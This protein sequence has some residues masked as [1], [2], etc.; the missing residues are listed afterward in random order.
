V[1]VSRNDIAT[2]R[3]QVVF[4]SHNAVV[5]KPTSSEKK[6]MISKTV[7]KSRKVRDTSDDATSD[8]RLGSKELPISATHD[9][10]AELRK[11]KKSSDILCDRQRII[12]PT[13]KARSSSKINTVKKELVK[14]L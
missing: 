5:K 9:Q 11:S 2:G 1:P 12:K 3:G 8:H 10:N 6:N 13:L 14:R 4:S 7:Q